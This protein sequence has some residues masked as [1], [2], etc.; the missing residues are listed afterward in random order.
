MTPIRTIGYR[1]LGSLLRRLKLKFRQ[2]PSIHTNY[3]ISPTAPLYNIDT[4]QYLGRNEFVNAKDH[5]FNSAAI[6]LLWHPLPM[7]CCGQF[8]VAGIRRR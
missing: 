4:V 1:W 6:L 3:I 2:Y 5:E 8:N 7:L